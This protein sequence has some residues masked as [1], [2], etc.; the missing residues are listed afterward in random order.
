MLIP[1]DITTVPRREDGI[2]ARACDRLFH[3]SAVLEC[4]RRSFGGV[5]WVAQKFSVTAMPLIPLQ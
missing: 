5:R 1:G 3:G 4:E 2:R